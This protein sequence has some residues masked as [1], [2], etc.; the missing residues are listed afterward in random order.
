[1]LEKDALFCT[2]SLLWCFCH[3]RTPLADYHI[4]EWSL[5]DKGKLEVECVLIQNDRYTS[6]NLWQKMTLPQ[7]EISKIKYFS[8]FLY[9]LSLLYKVKNIKDLPANH[10]LPFVDLAVLGGIWFGLIWCGWF[11]GFL[12]VWLLVGWFVEVFCL[13]VWVLGGIFCVF[14]FVFLRKHR[15]PEY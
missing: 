5:Q 12:V 8:L 6:E 13:I 3:N 7:S 2:L 4:T 11:G 15:W 14:C 1:M 10:P 9:H